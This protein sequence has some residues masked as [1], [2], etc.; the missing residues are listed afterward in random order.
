MTPYQRLG[1][2]IEAT[3]AALLFAHAGG[4]IDV[5][6]TFDPEQI[7]AALSRAGVAHVKVG[8]LA[9]A[10]HGVVGVSADTDAARSGD[11]TADRPQ[12]RSK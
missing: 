10:A 2:A 9:G 1:L 3:R 4:A 8:G 5:E 6:P 7:G 11:S 12:D